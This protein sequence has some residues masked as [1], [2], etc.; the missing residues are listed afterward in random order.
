M[1]KVV[2]LYSMLRVYSIPTHK[3]TFT[4]AKVEIVFSHKMCIKVI[5]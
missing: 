5:E 2:I 1:P 4:N 3:H